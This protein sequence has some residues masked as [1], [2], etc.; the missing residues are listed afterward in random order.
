M[1][2]SQNL[3][4]MGQYY[5]HLAEHA[6]PQ[7]AAYCNMIAEQCEDDAKSIDRQHIVI[8]ISVFAAVVLTIVYF[9]L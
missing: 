3:R 6:D 2:L 4:E 5:R 7:G 9:S 8:A 1:S